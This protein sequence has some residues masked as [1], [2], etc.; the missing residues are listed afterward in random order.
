MWQGHEHTTAQ[1]DF[2]TEQFVK[3]EEVAIWKIAKLGQ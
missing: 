3:L 1:K 2:K